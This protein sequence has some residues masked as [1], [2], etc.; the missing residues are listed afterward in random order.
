MA[1]IADEVQ[2]LFQKE[3]ATEGPG[4][5]GVAGE[6]AIREQI[7]KILNERSKLAAISGL[8]AAFDSVDVDLSPILTIW[9]DA[10]E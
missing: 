5:Y 4:F 9:F 10:N 2:E 7:P 1:R 8:K 6:V 3:S